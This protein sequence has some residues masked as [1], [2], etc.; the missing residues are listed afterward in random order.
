MKPGDYNGLHGLE[1][2][3]RGVTEK[4]MNMYVW[5]RLYNFECL[6]KKT[7]FCM[8]WEIMKIEHQ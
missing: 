6:F 5:N 7:I 1:R 3:Q 2:L 8:Q 4:R